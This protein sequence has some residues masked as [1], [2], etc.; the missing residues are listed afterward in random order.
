MTAAEQPAPRTR[1]GECNCPEGS[2]PHYHAGFDLTTTS[3]HAAMESWEKAEGDWADC[4]L[5]THL[6]KVEREAAAGQPPPDEAVRLLR[7]LVDMGEES[8]EAGLVN[9]AGRARSFL[10]ESESAS[11]PPTAAPPTAWCESCGFAH[12]I[13]WLDCIL[14]VPTAAASDHEHD[15][16]DPANPTA[17]EDVRHCTICGAV[18]RA[19]PERGASK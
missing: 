7:E 16:S 2:G 4:D 5:A 17:G 10:Q 15:W 1:L 6:R 11:P 3:G 8:R 9:L 12:E 19:A 18:E 13:G 14:A